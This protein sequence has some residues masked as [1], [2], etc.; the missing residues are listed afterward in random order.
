MGLYVCEDE[1]I[2][3]YSPTICI[4]SVASLPVFLKL[5]GRAALVAGG[6][7]GAAWKAELLAA[8]GADTR[9]FAAEPCE[10]MKELVAG[11]ENLSLISRAWQPGDL[12]G[13]AIAILDA[14]DEHEARAFRDAARAAGAL[15]NVIDNTEFCDFSFGSIV[16]RSPLVVA[17]STCGAAPVLAQAIRAKLEALLPASLSDWAGLARDWRKRLDPSLE[18]GQRRRFWE[19][20][21]DLVLRAGALKPVPEDF[22][23]LENALEAS[24]APPAGE[25][26]LVGAGPGDPELLTLKAVAALQSADIIV[27]G[28]FVSPRALE[29]ARREAERIDVGANAGA[30]SMKEP[31]IAAMLV[32]LASQG[33]RV[34]RLDGGDPDVFGRANEKILAARAAGVKVT[35][36]PGVTAALGAPEAR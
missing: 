23:A 15:V 7:I 14:E 36:V 10:R 19:R 17:I 22:A 4:A 21:V 9:I 33:K 28:N 24:A 5:E 20:F 3:K 1:F 25:I 34:V 16:N 13:A 18:T 11:H 8:V 6:S 32:R 29:L 27:Y 12:N 30:P 31:D 26:T 35:I 2:R